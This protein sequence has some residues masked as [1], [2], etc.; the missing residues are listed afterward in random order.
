MFLRGYGSGPSL[1]EFSHRFGDIVEG[2]V[3]DVGANDEFDRRGVG[4]V[5]VV[6]GGAEPFERDIRGVP[7]LFHG[8][9]HGEFDEQAVSRGEEESPKTLAVGEY[10]EILDRGGGEFLRVGLV[11]D[12]HSASGPHYPAVDGIFRVEVGAD[13]R[14]VFAGLSGPCDGE[15]AC[16]AATIRIEEYG[17]GVAYFAFSQVWLDRFVAVREEEDAGLFALQARCSEE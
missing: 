3:L 10:R 13:N 11:D 17:V 6:V 14:V 2:A 8:C 1:F 12:P 7:P 9:R 15:A 4:E 5:V 16:G